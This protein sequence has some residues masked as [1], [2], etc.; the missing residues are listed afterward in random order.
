MDLIVNNGITAISLPADEVGLLVQSC[1]WSGRTDVIEY[2]SAADHGSV[3]A[4]QDRNP[5]MS[6]GIN[7]YLMSTTTG[8]WT[9]AIG[10]SVGSAGLANY[11][12]ASVASAYFSHTWDGGYCI[13]DNASVSADGEANPRV[14]LSYKA[15][16]FVA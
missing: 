6:I 11:N 12:L 13:L 2:K 8:L 4:R 7:A 10:T 5:V 1:S 15:Y 16:P 14:D 9:M 3:V